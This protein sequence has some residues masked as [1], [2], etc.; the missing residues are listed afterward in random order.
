MPVSD[1]KR[2]SNAKWDA[3]NLSRMSLAI[4]RQLHDR[5]K[6]HVQETGETTNGFI[7]RS[8][9]ETIERDKQQKQ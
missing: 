5:M 4:P 1:K 2:A 8:I 7:R 3:D 6:A 9:E